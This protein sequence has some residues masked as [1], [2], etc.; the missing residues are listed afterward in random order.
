MTTTMTT[1][2]AAI[3][4]KRA[5]EQPFH[6]QVIIIIIIIYR[7]DG[8]FDEYCENGIIDE[9]MKITSGIRGCE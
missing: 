5:I 3:A 7:E 9:W 2:V 6:F 4:L 8:N 1:K